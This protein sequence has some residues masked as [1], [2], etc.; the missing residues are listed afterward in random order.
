MSQIVKQRIKSVLLCIIVL[1][2]IGLLYDALN[3]FQI[4]RNTRSIYGAVAG[5]IMSVIFVISGEYVVELI[6]K[7]DKVSDPLYKRV[8]HL[9]A[10]LVSVAVVWVLYLVVFHYFEK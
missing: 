1:P 3:G 10:L 6:G 9:L 5:L 2:L 7:K 8:F 4:L